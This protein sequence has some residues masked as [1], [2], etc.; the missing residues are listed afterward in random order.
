[1]AT[2]LLKEKRLNAL[3][4]VQLPF[5]RRFMHLDTIISM[6]DHD[7]F[8]CYKNI[9]SQLKGWLINAENL[10]FIM[11]NEPTDYFIDLL[12]DVLNT[13]KLR[14][15]SIS[16]PKAHNE[17]WNDANNLLTLKPGLVMAYECNTETNKILTKGGIK[18]IPLP[19]EHLSK[20]R[21]G[22]RCLSCPLKR[23]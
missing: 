2:R 14:F 22:P 1:M 15:F 23:D 16:S 6:I 4:V 21:G 9:L 5:K 18:V 10:D 3:I 17:Q 7:A 12:K 8:I 11:N 13:N 20:G 19:Y